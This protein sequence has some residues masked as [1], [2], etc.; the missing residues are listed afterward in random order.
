MATII[1]ID[2]YVKLGEQ[3]MA[4][5]DGRLAG[6]ILSKNLCSTVARDR[7]CDRNY[8]HRDIVLIYKR[9]KGNGKFI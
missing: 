7:R 1:S 3:T 6:D 8:R 2:R 5:P 9:S 4:T